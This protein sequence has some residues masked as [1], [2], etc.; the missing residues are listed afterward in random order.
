MAGAGMPALAK[1]FEVG[2]TAVRGALRRCGVQTRSRVE[3]SS[4]TLL[5]ETQS[6]LAIERYL[7]T[8]GASSSV[9]REF[10]VSPATIKRLVKLAGV[11]RPY[12]HHDS[13]GYVTVRC[14]P[15]LISMARTGATTPRVAEHRLVMAR[16]L[17]RPLTP[18][19][20]VHHING[21]RDDNRI[22]NLQLR[23]GQHGIGVVY[24]CLDCGSTNVEPDVIHAG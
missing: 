19:E 22:E 13:A 20:S 14:P 21:V 8:N 16:H 18:H 15:D 24:R 11:E 7:A 5:D 17:G 9:A 1:R 23:Q 2:L 3:A 12:R 10:G 6:A 4:R